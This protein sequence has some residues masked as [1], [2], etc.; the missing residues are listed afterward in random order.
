[1]IQVHTGEAGIAGAGAS[2]HPWRVG[3]PEAHP[4][5]LTVSDD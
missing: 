3:L 1:M 5:P 2:R 4:R